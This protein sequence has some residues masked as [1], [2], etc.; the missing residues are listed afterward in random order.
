MSTLEALQTTLA[1]EHAAVFLYG[2][3]GGQTSQSA[4]P[5]QFELVSEGHDTHRRRRDDLVATVRALGAEPVAASAVYELPASIG[6]PAGV[7]AAAVELETRCCEVYAALVAETTGERRRWAVTALTQSAVVLT[8][9]S[10][11]PQAFPGA[12]EL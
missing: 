12:P 5:E 3:L 9:W 8:E 10:A 6:T 1:A 4:R 7:T 11:A 2:V